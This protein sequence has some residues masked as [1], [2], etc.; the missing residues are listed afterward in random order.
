MYVWDRNFWVVGKEGEEKYAEQSRR[1]GGGIVF[2]L[3]TPPPFRYHSFLL[4]L[5]SPFQGSRQETSTRYCAS[6]PSLAA[7]DKK[8]F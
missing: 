8:R 7:L 5:D 3:L 4:L 1:R 2:V 6:N